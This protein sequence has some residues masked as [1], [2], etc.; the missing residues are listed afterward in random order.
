MACLPNATRAS[1]HLLHAFF[2][3]CNDRTAI[4]PSVLTVALS[5]VD[6]CLNAGNIKLD[7][8]VAKVQHL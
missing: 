6:R 1:N 4:V 8:A 5:Q 7:Q 2:S 3:L